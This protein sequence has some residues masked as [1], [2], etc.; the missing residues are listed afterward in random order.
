MKLLIGIL[1]LVSA[2][3]AAHAADWKLAWSDEFDGHGLPDSG[4]APRGMGMIGMRAR[5]RSIGGEVSVDSKEG[6]GVAIEV[7]V[8]ARRPEP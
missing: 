5:A 6:K 4:A 8:P 7:R 3:T 2:A 1:L